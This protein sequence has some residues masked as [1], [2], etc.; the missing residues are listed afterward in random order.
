MGNIEVI[1]NNTIKSDDDIKRN[2]QQ[3]KENSSKCQM[4]TRVSNLFVWIVMGYDSIFDGDEIKGVFATHEKA[5]EYAKHN[6]YQDPE[7]VPVKYEVK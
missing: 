1:F 4:Q 5:V 3:L 6:N 2:I 7:S